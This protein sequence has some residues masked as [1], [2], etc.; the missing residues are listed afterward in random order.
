MSR[1]LS[2]GGVSASGSAGVCLPL[3]LGR[4]LPLGPEGVHSP[5][6]H[7]QADNPRQTPPQA[8]TPLGRHSLPTSRHKPPPQRWPLHS[9][10]F[11]YREHDFTWGRYVLPIFLLKTMNIL[12]HRENWTQAPHLSLPMYMEFFILKYLQR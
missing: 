9:C 10:S 3:G 1:F 12:A 11:K 8:D 4:C 5:G 2:G 6:R 7:P